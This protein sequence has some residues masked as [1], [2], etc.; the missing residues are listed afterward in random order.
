MLKTTWIFQ[1]IDIMVLF[2]FFKTTPLL[3]KTEIPPKYTN[4]LAIKFEWTGQFLYPK[5]ILLIISY[6]ETQDILVLSSVNRGFRKLILDASGGVSFSQLMSNQLN[7]ENL[8]EADL[9]KINDCEPLSVLCGI[10]CV[11]STIFGSGCAQYQLYH[12]FGLA[13]CIPFTSSVA[14][15]TSVKFFE[16]RYKQ[17]QSI[18]YENRQEI[19][20]LLKKKRIIG[21]REVESREQE[22]QQQML[23]NH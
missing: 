18:A 3:K 5:I 11:F 22:A 1:S 13:T 19:L 6:L 4:S 21:S 23:M 12:A 16:N 7:L 15:C 9:K 10:F 17:N 8:I 2:M 20:S 14:A